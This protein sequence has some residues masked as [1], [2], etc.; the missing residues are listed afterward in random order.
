MKTTSLTLLALTQYHTPSGAY[1]GASTGFDSSAV[2]GPSY[3]KSKSAATVAV[4]LNNFVGTI[5]I[6]GTLDSDPATAEWTT[7]QTYGNT[8]TPTS[9]TTSSDIAGNIVWLQAKVNNFTSGT[10]TKI[11]VSY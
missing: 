2:K 3:Y 7:L 9:T 1:D 11:A 6:Q 8:T 4:F 5:E 10:I